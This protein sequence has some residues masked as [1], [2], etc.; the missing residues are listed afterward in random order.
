MSRRV[1]V[2]LADTHAGH[3]LSLMNPESWLLEQDDGAFRP[4]H[5]ALSATQQGLWAHYQDDVAA[6]AEMADGAQVDVVHVGDVTWGL[7]YPAGLV[8]TRMADQLTL[9]VA[10]LE[11]WLALDNVASLTLV[12]GTDS[13]ELGEASAPLLVAGQLAT[14]HPERR[15]STVS[16]LLG[17]VDGVAVDAAHHGP[18]PGTREWLMGNNVRHYTR[19]L[20]L[21]EVVRGG[22]PPALVVRAH[23]HDYARETVRVGQWC[24]EAVVLP[25]YAGL[26]PYAQQATR[27]I[28]RITCGLVAVEIEDGRLR[29]VRALVHSKDIRAQVVL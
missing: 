16:H 11:P 21:G 23:Y 2:F 17:Q 29:E 25:A 5:P 10:N 24:T 14:A 3:K 12:T 1:L 28:S 4:Y 7:R 8:S 19:S 18:H 27:S 13:H 6:V 15:I 9:A 26:T 20:M 22:E